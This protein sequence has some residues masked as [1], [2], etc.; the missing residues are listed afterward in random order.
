V[1]AEDSRVA[2]ARQALTESKQS[3]YTHRPAAEWHGRVQAALESLLAY[4]DEPEEGARVFLSAICDALD[5]STIDGD[6]WHR[7]TAAVQ[8]I[9][10][11]VLEADN[12]AA[13]WRVGVGL[14]RQ[15]INLK[16][17]PGL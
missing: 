17:G 9:I 13:A 10:A 5:A 1:T 8:G 15:E 14:L 16:G 12:P 6:N 3:D 2:V 7:R 4:V 11:F